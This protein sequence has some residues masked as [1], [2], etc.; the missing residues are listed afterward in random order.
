MAKERDWID[1]ANLGSNIVQNLQLNDAQGKLGAMASLAA[2]E[3][4]VAGMEDDRRE[5]IFKANRNVQGLRTLSG[6]NR[7][8][9]LALVRQALTDFEEFGITSAA[10]RAYEDKQRVSAMIEEYEALADECAAALSSTER[11]E[12]ELCARYLVEQSL[13]SRYLELRRKQEELKEAESQLGALE[14]KC[15]LSKVASV[16]GAIL[17]V[18]GVFSLGMWVEADNAIGDEWIPELGILLAGIVFCFFG[19]NLPSRKRAKTQKATVEKLRLDLKLPDE[20][21]DPVLE[22]HKELETKSSSELKAMQV[23]REALILK[24]LKTTPESLTYS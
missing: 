4:A 9:V 22:S 18:A 17:C 3:Q 19:A 15:A 8:G 5:I 11:T 13:L 20:P 10:F 24:V 23:K 2:R 7:A 21:F 16:M 6:E 14:K 1:Y 12:A